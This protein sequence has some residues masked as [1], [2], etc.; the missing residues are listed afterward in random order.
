MGMAR[1]SVIRQ[2]G[3]KGPFFS[4]Y[5]IPP[6]YDGPMH[7][8]VTLDYIVVLYGEVVL[9]LQNGSQ[10]TLRQG[11]TSVQQGTMHSWA[12]PSNEWARLLSVMLPAKAILVDD[13]ELEPYWPFN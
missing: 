9:T 11:D 8:T 7:R 1:R 6:K 5:D 12:N 13:K 2:T 10:V 4:T 3:T